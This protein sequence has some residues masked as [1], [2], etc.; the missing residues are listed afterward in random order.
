[1]GN[2]RGLQ[3][4]ELDVVLCCVIKISNGAHSYLPEGGVTLYFDISKD[5]FIAF[6][7]V[8]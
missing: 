7:K 8:S 2:V 5:G 6:I 1:M 3:R 4:S